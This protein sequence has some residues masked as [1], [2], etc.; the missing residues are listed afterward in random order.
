MEVYK[1]TS[2]KEKETWIW[3]SVILQLL[4]CNFGEITLLKAVNI[5]NDYYTNHKAGEWDVKFFV[6]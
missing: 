5:R 2:N 6:M 4:V 3:K 1:D